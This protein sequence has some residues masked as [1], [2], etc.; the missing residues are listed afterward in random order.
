MSV[1]SRV[2]VGLDL[3]GGG[4]DPPRQVLD[5]AGGRLDGGPDRLGRLAEADG[6]LLQRAQD[7]A[8]PRADGVDRLADLGDRVAQVAPLDR[9]EPDLL[10]DRVEER[11]LDPLDHLARAPAPP[12]TGPTRRC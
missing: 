8:D 2:S 9:P 5:V 1:S 12:P 7:L 11:R 10:E 4:V 6:G 3:G